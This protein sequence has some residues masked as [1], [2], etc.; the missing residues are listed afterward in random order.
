MPEKDKRQQ[1]E[2]VTRTKGNSF[3]DFYLKRE[4]LMGIFEKGYEKPSPIQEETIPIALAGRCSQPSV[5]KCF[6]SVSLCQGY[7]CTCQEWHRENCRFCD[8]LLGESRPGQ[9]YPSSAGACSNSRA[10]SAN[11]PSDQR[12]GEALEGR[13]HGHHWRDQ[14]EGRHHAFVQSCSHSRC[15]PWPVRVVQTRSWLNISYA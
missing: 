3:E 10:C 1:T 14:F 4:L 9:E 12:A 7:P 8:P 6:V 11:L 13:G 2:D 5:L 15:H